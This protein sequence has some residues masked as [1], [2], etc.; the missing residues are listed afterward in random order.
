M[1]TELTEDNTCRL[2]KALI[3]RYGITYEEAMY[4]LASFRLNLVCN[5]SIASSIALQAALITAVNTGKRAFHGGV[6]VVIPEGVPSRF[7]WP[8]QPS[9]AAICS[10]LGAKLEPL[11]AGDMIQT[12]FFG[13]PHYPK[14]DDLLVSATGWRG[15]VSPATAPICISSPI[16]F[17]LGGTIAGALAVAKG[18][19]RIAGIDIRHH[20]DSAGV[21]LWDLSADWREEGSDGPDL[22]YLPQKL[23]IL[24]LG[25]LGQAYLWTLGLLPFAKPQKAEFFLQ[26]FD[27]VV[28]ANLGT[29]LLCSAESV[30]RLKTRLCAEWMENRRLR[31]RIIERP[32][33]FRI[34][35]N[36]D[37]PLVALCGFDS[38]AAR[39]LLEKPGFDLIVE[40]G[41]GGDI[42]NFDH[43]FLHTFPDATKK[44]EEIWGVATDAEA[45]PELIK[46]FQPDERCGIV[47]RTLAGKA[48]STSF[49]GAIAAAL[50]VGEVLR[51]LHGGKRSEFLRFQCR[52]DQCP[53]AVHFPEKYQ[54]RFARSGYVLARRES[55]PNSDDLVPSI[56]VEP[57]RFRESLAQTVQDPPDANGDDHNVAREGMGQ[58]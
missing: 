10:H 8:G 16:D 57:E 29:G 38:A 41:I 18:F 2:A 55:S 53:K 24:G 6:H 30:G 37:E 49:V 35:P 58:S 5:Q 50:V 7:P 20:N 4:K 39:R 40:A 12:I 44:P 9:L 33:D 1:K 46:A 11:L 27:R 23:W 45:A 13:Q 32:F 14:A 34:V 31:T 17:A 15:A 47:A 21:S 26:D 56:Q 19:L 42:A 3:E 51:G 25:H 36:D 52:R 54:R 43:I 22:Q 48:I 28:V